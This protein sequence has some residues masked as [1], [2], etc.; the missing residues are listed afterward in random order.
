MEDQHPYCSKARACLTGSSATTAACL[1]C[2]EG[3]EHAQGCTCNA[4][5]VGQG[6]ADEDADSDDDARDDGALVSQRQSKDD[7]GG[8]T[9]SAG[10]SYIL[11]QP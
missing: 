9:S 1:T 7:I 4:E 2:G 6:E 10:V 8:S 5:H 11:Q 3:G